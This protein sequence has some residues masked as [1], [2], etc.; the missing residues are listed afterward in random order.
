MACSGVTSAPGCPFGSCILL[1]SLPVLRRRKQAQDSEN[2]I[3]HLVWW[4]RVSHTAALAMAGRRKFGGSDKACHMQLG[5]SLC[6]ATLTQT[7]SV[8]VKCFRGHL[9]MDMHLAA[10][11]F[12]ASLGLS[13]GLCSSS[14]YIFCTLCED[15]CRILSVFPGF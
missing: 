5:L 2:N 13:I 4:L 15:R 14:K 7:F 8:T 3:L 12:R 9:S 10:V 1:C 11:R 6:S